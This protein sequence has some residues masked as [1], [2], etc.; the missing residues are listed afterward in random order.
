MA[1]QFTE[2]EDGIDYRGESLSPLARLFVLLMAA[3]MF[4]VPAFLIALV[5]W[6]ALTWSTLLAA[7]GI[8][9]FAAVG[10]TFAWMG[11][12][13][14]KAAMFDAR[15]R[16]LRMH[17]RGPLGRRE[18]QWPFTAIESILVRRTKGMEDPDVFQLRMRIADRRRPYDFGMFGLQREAEAWQVRLQSLLSTVE[19]GP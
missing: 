1:P 16:V 13:P 14:L 15:R 12:A 5:S 9:A 18:R 4:V 17:F 11:L 10:A 19:R 7:L 8:V 3:A 2:S 6:T